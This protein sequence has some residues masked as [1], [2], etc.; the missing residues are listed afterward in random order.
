MNMND[1]ELRRI[2][3]NSCKEFDEKLEF[4][5]NELCKLNPE[6]KNIKDN[7]FTRLSPT[8]GCWDGSIPDDIINWENI[9]KKEMKVKF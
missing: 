1:K 7:P 4:I 3:Y 9:P 6:I 2:V 5:H 8:R